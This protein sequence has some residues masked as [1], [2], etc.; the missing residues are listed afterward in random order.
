MP[1][2][3]LLVCLWQCLSQWEPRVCCDCTGEHPELRPCG[4]PAHEAEPAGPRG[5]RLSGT[6]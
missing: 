5:G 3:E 2:A 6:I 1:K 4:A